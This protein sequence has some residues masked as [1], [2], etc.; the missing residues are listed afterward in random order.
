LLGHHPSVAL[1][2][3]HQA[4]T[5]TG[6]PRQVARATPA[7]AAA[8]A[9]AAEQLPT[10]NRTVLDAAVRRALHRAD[11]SRP[12]VAHSGVPP[13]LPLLDGTD[14]H[15]YLGWDVGDERD[16]PGLARRLPRMV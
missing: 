9:A 7:L 14:S 3:G 12:T 1:W 4:P 2:C 6:R 8:R 11:P 13:H 10:W 5:E 16:L 15:L